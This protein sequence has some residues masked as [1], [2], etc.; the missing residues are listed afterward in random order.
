MASRLRGDRWR[1]FVLGVAS[2]VFSLCAVGG[3]GAGQS[4]EASVIGTVT[5]ESQGVMPGVT[6]TA[7][8]PALQ[9]TL[10]GAEP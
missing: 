9:G 3:A 2:A 4:T 6:V 1:I 8:S 7:T 5:D 10:Y